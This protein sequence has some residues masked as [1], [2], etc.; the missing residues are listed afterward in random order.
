MNTDT[1]RIEEHPDRRQPFTVWGTDR[2]GKWEAVLFTERREQATAYITREDE[3]RQRNGS[4]AG[5]GQ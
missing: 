2:D 4:I 3:R 1:W 5:A